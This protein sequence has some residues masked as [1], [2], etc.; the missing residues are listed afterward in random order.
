VRV[1]REGI[2]H[3]GVRGV[4]LLQDAPAQLAEG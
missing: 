4:R 2:L 1:L 3:G